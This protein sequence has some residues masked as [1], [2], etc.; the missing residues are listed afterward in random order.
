MVILGSRLLC[1][2]VGSLHVRVNYRTNPGPLSCG[3]AAWCYQSLEEDTHTENN[4]QLLHII[5]EDTLFF[6][7]VLLFASLTKLLVTL[8]LKVPSVYKPF[9]CLGLM[10]VSSDCFLLYSWTV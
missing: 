9:P 1:F 6:V 10:Y 4:T 8:S 7:P 2:L 3:P 5:I